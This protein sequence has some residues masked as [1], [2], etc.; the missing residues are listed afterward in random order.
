M[1]KNSIWRSPERLYLTKDGAAARVTDPDI[2]SLLV[3]KGGELPVARAVELGLVTEA[4]KPGPR[5]KELDLGEA[6]AEEADAADEPPA[7]GVV[8]PPHRKGGGAPAK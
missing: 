8:M 5:A 7:S 2:A 1:P 6:P 3:T 4:G